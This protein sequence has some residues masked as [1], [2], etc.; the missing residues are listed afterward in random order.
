MFGLR[1]AT[2]KISMWLEVVSHLRFSGSGTRGSISPRVAVRIA[3]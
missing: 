1:A 2:Y 3:V